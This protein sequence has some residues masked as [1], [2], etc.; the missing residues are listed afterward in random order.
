MEKDWYDVSKNETAERHSRYLRSYR[1][2]MEETVLLLSGGRR[3]P[4]QEL[5]DML[6]FEARFAKVN[7]AFSLSLSLLLPV[8]LS[9]FS[10][11]SS[12][13]LNATKSILLYFLG[14]K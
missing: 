13:S 8:P 5:D 11:L 12:A 3:E 4:L 1:N 9:S 6:A 14:V 10:P 2:L 7:F